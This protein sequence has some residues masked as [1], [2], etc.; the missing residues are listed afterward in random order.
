MFN[1][2]YTS[3]RDKYCRFCDDSWINGW[4]IKLGVYIHLIYDWHTLNV[5]VDTQKSGIWENHN[6]KY[7]DGIMT[8]VINTANVIKVL[9]I[10]EQTKKRYEKF[11]FNKCCDNELLKNQLQNIIVSLTTWKKRIGNIP[12]VLNTILKQT[13]SPYKIVINLSSEEFSNKEKDIPEDVLKFIENNKTIEINWVEGE[14]SRQWKKFVPTML[15][16]PN[17]WVIC[18]DDDKLY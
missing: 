8:K 18:I 14:N 10:E 4:L 2:K 15:K 17:D 5:I 3:L 7:R 9:E 1:D 13:M 12:T 11:D 16:Y 6:S